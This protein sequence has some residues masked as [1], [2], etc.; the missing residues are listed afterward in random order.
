[1]VVDKLALTSG[2]HL[3]VLWRFMAGLTGLSVVGWE[4]ICKTTQMA[5]VPVSHYYR[6]DP[7]SYYHN[8]YYDLLL[9]HCLFDKMSKALKLL[10]M[11]VDMKWRLTLVNIVGNDIVEMLGCG[12]CSVGDVHG[13]FRMLNIAKNSLTHE[14]ITYFRTFPLKILNHIHILDLH[15]KDALD[16]LAGTL[17]VMVN[18]KALCPYIRAACY[19]F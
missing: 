11:R 5:I 18:L 6:L 16:C 17:S 8:L 12:L 10:V 7:T 9:I 4:L 1:M 13:C 19:Y 14:A 15:D 3:D 2:R